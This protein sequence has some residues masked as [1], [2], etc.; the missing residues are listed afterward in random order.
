VALETFAEHPLAGIGSGS[1]RVAWLQKRSFAEPVRDAHSLELETAAELGLVGLAAL[2]AFLAGLGAGAVAAV[3]RAGPAAAGA[4]A[5]LAVWA[6]HSAVDW[7]WEMPALSLVALV[8]GAWLLTVP[9]PAP[10]AI[11]REP[12]T[13]ARAEAAGAR[14]P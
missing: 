6:L 3:R 12:A 10:V 14:S 5:A 7:D 4:T 8:L 13:P 11:R 2:A 1:F 9:A